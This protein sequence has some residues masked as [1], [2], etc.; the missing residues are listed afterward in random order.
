M[1]RDVL[2]AME[3]VFGAGHWGTF[4]S[5]GGLAVCLQSAGEFEAAAAMQ[6]SV[7][8]AMERVR[9]LAKRDGGR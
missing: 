1:Q 6:R 4:A 9:R 5:R 2:A 3:R 7:L 8:L